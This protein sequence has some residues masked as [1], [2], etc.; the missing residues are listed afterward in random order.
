LAHSDVLSDRCPK[1]FAPLLST[2]N[3]ANGGKF[4][5][6]QVSSSAFKFILSWI[7]QENA[8]ESFDEFKHP[9]DSLCFLEDVYAVCPL[10]QLD[11]LG[12]LIK[13]YWNFS[14]SPQ[15]FGVLYHR[16]CGELKNSKSGRRIWRNSTNM[17][18]KLK[19][20]SHAD[21]ARPM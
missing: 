2:P 1:V 14:I 13:A 10:F 19:L 18:I 8:P 3:P 15:N 7:Y 16:A 6:D 12:K 4:V 20:L 11:T 17:R 9:D 5:V 21:R